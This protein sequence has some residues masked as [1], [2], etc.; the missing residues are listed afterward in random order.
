MAAVASLGIH[1]PSAIRYLVAE[2]LLPTDPPQDA[3]KWASVPT[4]TYD[5]GPHEEE[6]ICTKHCVVWSRGGTIRRVFR[7]DIE[8]ENVTQAFFTSFPSDVLSSAVSANQKLTA[9]SRRPNEPPSLAARSKRNTATAEG[10][11]DVHTISASEHQATH[12]Q[13]QTALLDRALVIVLETHLHIFSLSGTNYVVQ[14][15]FKVEA[16]YPLPTG[17]ILKKQNSRKKSSLVLQC[18]ATP[19][20]ANSFIKP[21]ASTLDVK[22]LVSDTVVPS[23]GR[24]PLLL[25]PLQSLRHR[26]AQRS[27]LASPTLF[28]LFDPLSELGTA[29][30]VDDPS[31]TFADHRSRHSRLAPFDDQGG[32]EH[33]LYISE[34]D[35]LCFPGLACSRNTPL[36]FAVTENRKKAQITVWTISY[37][38]SPTKLSYVDTAPHSIDRSSLRPDSSQDY[39]AGTGATTPNAQGLHHRRESNGVSRS[40]RQSSN[41][42]S[43]VDTNPTLDDPQSL[44]LA[45]NDPSKL[46]KTSRRVSSLLARA[47]LS[48]THDRTVIPDAPNL[49]GKH[50]G[51]LAAS[52]VRASGRRSFAADFHE[53]DDGPQ[54]LGNSQ[55][56]LVSEGPSRIELM[57]TATNATEIYG[58]EA[59]ATSE[60]S[61]AHAGNLEQI[62]FRKVHS[63]ACE[64][65]QLPGEGR[66]KSRCSTRVFTMT[67][68]DLG[69]KSASETAVVIL[70]I[71]DRSNGR[72]WKLQIRPWKTAQR[73]NLPV[74]ASNK[75][76]GYGFH[77]TETHQSDVL[78]AGKVGKPGNWRILTI[79]TDA[80]GLH[81]MSLQGPCSSPSNIEMPSPLNLHNPHHS[82]LDLRTN[83]RGEGGLGRIFDLGLHEMVKLR[84]LN[85]CDQILVIDVGNKSHRLEIQLRPRHPQIYRIIEICEA[86][87]SALAPLQ[88]TFLR[89]W[90][91]VV[92]W[93]HARPEPETEIEWIALIVLLFSLV[94]PYLP[95][96]ASRDMKPRKRQKGVLLRSSS[97]ANTDLASWEIMTGCEDGS[98]GDTSA[99]IG[100]GA[101]E[102]IEDYRLPTT[103]KSGK[104]SETQSKYADTLATPSS[105]NR[106]FLQHC[107][108]LS[109]DFV[110]SPSGRAA[111]GN[112]GYLPSASCWQPALRCAGLQSILVALHLLREEFKLSVLDSDASQRLTPI[113]AQLGGWLGWPHW[114]FHE[115][116][117]YMR[118]S[119]EMR[120]WLFD[121]SR[122]NALDVP[123]EPLPPPSILKHIEDIVIKRSGYLSLLDI[124]DLPRTVSSEFEGT[125]KTALRRLIKLTPRTHT[126]TELIHAQVTERMEACVERLAER[127]L[128]LS[129]LE[130][131][132]E[133]VAFSLRT[134]LAVCQVEPPT[135][136]NGDELAMVG[137]EDIAMVKQAHIISSKGGKSSSVA[138]HE[139]MRDIHTVCQTSIE[140]E[141]IG[142]YDSY[143]EIDRQS[144]TRLIFNEDQRFAEAAKILHPL[145]YPAAR[146]VAEPEWSDTEFLE[147]Q[148]DLAKVIAIRT[149]AVSLGRGLM[150]YN[151]RLPLLTDKYPI[152]GFTLSCIIKP[153][154]VTVTADRAVYT[155]EK[156]SWAFFHAGVE[157]GLSISKDAKGIDTSWI[158]FN[159]PRELNNRHAGF[160]FAMGLN[161]HLKTIAKWVAFKYLTPKH[162]MTSVGL[163]L[164]LSASYIGTMDTLV[165]RL[166]SVH[167]TRMLPMGA[168]ELNISP[169]TQ[170]S[171]IMGIGLLYCD[172]QHRRM[173]EVMLSEMEDMDEDDSAVSLPRLR[174]EGYRLAAGFALGYINLGRGRDLKGL[175]D[176]QI[177]ER[178][179]S[180]S[181]GYRKAD[182]VQ[183][184]DKATAGATVAIALVFMKTQHY[185][186]ARKIDIPDTLHQ[187]DYLRPDHFLL[188]TVARNLIMWDEIHATID[189]MRQQL[190][191]SM[192][193]DVSLSTIRS[194]TSEDLPLLNI[195]AGLCLSV[196]LRHAG[197]G[198]H[199]VRDLLCHYLV[200]FIRICRLPAL[201]YDG[202]LAR[203][204]VR[205]CQ[206][207][208][209]LAASCVMAG[210][211]DLQLFR[212]LRSLHGRTDTETPYGS[213]LATHFA[214]GILFLG[215]GSHSFGT[216]NIAV[217]SLLCAFYPLFPSTVLDNRSHLQ[218]FRHLWVLATE[219]RCLVVRD[220][221][222]H[223][224]ISLPVSITLKTGI[225]IAM[226]APCLIPELRTISNVR[227]NDSEYWPVTLDMINN[228]MHSIAFQQHQSMYVL[229]RTAYN[230]HNSVFGAMM[231]ALNHSRSTHVDEKRALEWVFSLTAFQN[232]DTAAQ[233]VVLSCLPV[234]ADYKSLRGTVLD[235]R[236]VLEKVCV[237]STISDRLWNLRILLACFECAMDTRGIAPWM[238][239]ETI[240]RLRS[241]LIMRRTQD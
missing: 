105:R 140:I 9:G 133:G 27:L 14:L 158:L 146:C 185:A 3:Y 144:V 148:Q 78:D 74:R 36:L 90:C 188:R 136:W 234:L 12:H 13:Y 239:H 155:E 227:T 91:D 101:W 125:T 114:G 132:P 109:E 196:G 233:A 213:H 75:D 208:V 202:K 81:H 31:E 48:A 173:T 117:I 190:P 149:L 152:H 218:A 226:T 141:P 87:T 211:G 229:R 129:D 50:S 171:G 130:T 113:L 186:L 161:G 205:N 40:L 84:N 223:Q 143:T 195:I 102:W 219:C 172:T 194:L 128:R 118:E 7:F 77:V 23:T 150:F 216:S 73:Q 44:D 112:Q 123:D 198:C 24:D 165:T 170:T 8:E 85:F 94:V 215:G 42:L 65:A 32:E 135:R 60:I 63:I 238:G 191:I 157:A 187:F 209:A 97:G 16:A 69:N 210:S 182:R 184:L 110:E 28:C 103:A 39:G 121:E 54:P 231:H 68:L 169:L 193:H 37:L 22:D 19:A 124:V 43:R 126:I 181:I 38:C 5:H 76:Q 4:D 222:T 46:A 17:I 237:R 45:F 104:F 131:L 116:S 232:F 206:D 56:K 106:D 33:L 168:A 119:V 199:E 67:T 160:L 163:L 151:A 145:M 66:S 174:D 34:K 35:E 100:K 166:L 92:A 86:V 61:N 179:L 108:S 138:L 82:M 164:G 15:P 52:F 176:M 55:A 207:L 115:Q 6:L 25:P 147:A 214:I 107:K 220:V 111:L 21:Q 26:S 29:A 204:T 70:C 203:I 178:L 142:L 2:G 95:A 71:M 156:V 241:A 80:T 225:E 47:D 120:C 51:R 59:S 167:V 221:K 58:G 228:P 159:R 200:Q 79:G 137:R 96:Q 88:E 18:T 240:Q 192:Q 10:R 230:S 177:T 175:H 98:R 1:E 93:L 41:D 99:W 62:A 236:L 20:Q 53:H 217:A 49:Q 30:I 154:K 11:R 83:R 224:P 212:R 201:H 134:A 162:S 183:I 127:G 89:G 153:G 57:E 235:D 139:T 180:L 122:I 64:S 72:L 189:W 197:S